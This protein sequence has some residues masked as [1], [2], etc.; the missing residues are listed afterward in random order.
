MK[1]IFE[2]YIII[3]RNAAVFIILSLT[4][5]SPA[6]AQTLIKGEIRNSDGLPV[7]NAHIQIIG[8]YDGGI[9][10]EEGKFHFT[11]AEKGL[12]KLKISHLNYKTD[13]IMIPDTVSAQTLSCLEI[14]LIPKTSYTLEDAVVSVSSFGITDS[15]KNSLLDSYDIYT[16]PLGNADIAMSLRILP[17]LSDRGDKEGFFIHGGDARET[18]VFIDGIEIRDLFHASHPDAPGR[19][20]F[21][22]GMFKGITL[23][24]GGY[25]AEYGNGLSGILNLSTRDMPD[26]SFIS[27]SLSPFFAGA[28]Y[29]F[30]NGQRNRYTEINYTYTNSWYIRPFLKKEWHY[31]NPND[32]HDLNIRSIIRL[33]ADSEIRFLCI[34]SAQRLHMGRTLSENAGTGYYSGK[35]KYLMGYCI[36]TLHKH[37]TKIN[38]SGASNISRIRTEYNSHDVAKNGNTGENTENVRFRQ[39]RISLKRIFTKWEYGVGSEWYSRK[40]DPYGSKPV[41]MHCGSFHIDLNYA[42]SSDISVNGGI[43]G[44]YG[45]DSHCFFMPRA[46]LSWRIRGKTNPYAKDWGIFTLDG[47]RYSRILENFAGNEYIGPLREEAESYH[48]TYQIKSRTDR[49]LRTQ[50]HMKN[51]R[52]LMRTTEMPPDN[53][54]EGYAKG[55]DI[56]WKDKGL[57]ENTE[58]WISYSYTASKRKFRDY[59]EKVRPDFVIPHNASLI[60]KHYMP[61]LSS[62]FN[63]A[64]TYRSGHSYRNPGLPSE[65]FMKSHT[66]AV[67]NMSLSWNYLFSA[68][69][70]RGVFVV[71]IDN[72]LN[73]NPVYDYRFLPSKNREGFERIEISSPAS[74]MIFFGIFFNIGRDRREE[75]I[76]SYL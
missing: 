72:I 7:S 39:A 66:P 32:I 4:F 61:R 73:R 29:G 76:N 48:L 28:G 5:L 35:N 63:T 36:Y 68:G 8:S 45:P 41:R 64:L 17:G 26:E 20:K 31:K 69:N 10:G 33:G 14:R 40:K 65:K 62:M 13:T 56:F 27:A 59:P 37:N 1:R 19:M 6:H 51:Y 49:I 25:S 38:I 54:G 43:R 12:L 21:Q 52:R 34:A 18:A 53:R 24:S 70:L 9:S 75:I 58:Y 15:G 71:H 57:I 47:G 11:T 3:R 50:I 22:P 46:S 2:P 30:F 74:R 23:K 16:N 44:E 42:I 67:I 60:V 55:F